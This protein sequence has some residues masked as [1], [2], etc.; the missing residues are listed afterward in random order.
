MEDSNTT[1][2]PSPSPPTTKTYTNGTNVISLPTTYMLLKS[3]LAHPPCTHGDKSES[4]W[5]CSPCSDNFTPRFWDATATLLDYFADFFPTDTTL[6]QSLWFHLL[7]MWQSAVLWLHHS[8]VLSTHN[9]NNNNTPLSTRRAH[10]IQLAS[11]FQSDFLLSRKL[12]ETVIYGADKMARGSSKLSESIIHAPDGKLDDND[13]NA[14]PGITTL[15]TGPWISGLKPWQQWLYAGSPGVAA[16]TP[17]DLKKGE[18]RLR[19]VPMSAIAIID[20]HTSRAREWAAHLAA[21]DPDTAA[22]KMARFDEHAL[23]F[24]GTGKSAEYTSVFGQRVRYTLVN[25]APPVCRRPGLVD[26]DVA[27]GNPS[28]SLVDDCLA[29]YKGQGAY[30]AQ[31]GFPEV[32]EGQDGG[33]G[34][35]E[36]QEEVV[37][38]E[39]NG[40]FDVWTV[41]EGREVVEKNRFAEGLKDVFED[42]G[43][44][45][46]RRRWTDR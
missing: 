33:D 23:G 6:M 14:P 42:W 32:K 13:N 12:F 4:Q 45:G 40:W 31:S 35:E 15:E 39:E 8:E 18:E 20:K 28:L 5:P 29:M 19:H 3:L 9:N 41:V 38:D 34:E 21:R 22:E 26:E 17:P 1:P 2:S 24:P 10:D 43:S 25:G 36:E 7:D 30:M 37:E 44:V 11:Q 46:E 27:I 16:P